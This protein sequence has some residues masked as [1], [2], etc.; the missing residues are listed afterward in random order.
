ME[1]ELTK[2][3]PSIVQGSLPGLPLGW[4]PS[5]ETVEEDDSD[6]DENDEIRNHSSPLISSLP[7]ITTYENKPYLTIKKFQYQNL[8]YIKKINQI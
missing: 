6:F 4:S 3:R 8:I 7:S 5:I 1:S 2:R